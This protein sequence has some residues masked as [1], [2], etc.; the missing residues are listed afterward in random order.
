LDRRRR[1]AG[2]TPRMAGIK[3]RG[4]PSCAT[5]LRFAV[6]ATLAY[7]PEPSMARAFAGT[8]PS[9]RTPCFAWAPA[10]AFRG[11]GVRRDERPPDTRLIPA[12]PPDCC[13]CPAHPAALGRPGQ[14]LRGLPVH[15]ANPCATHSLRRLGTGPSLPWLGRSP[16]RASTGHSPYSGSPP[17]ASSV[18]ASPRLRPAHPI[19]L[20]AQ[21]VSMLRRK[22]GF[23]VALRSLTLRRPTATHQPVPERIA[24]GTRGARLGLVVGWMVPPC[25]ASRPSENRVFRRPAKLW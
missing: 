22:R 4:L 6:P 12:H 15:R 21:L 24:F 8:I 17:G 3:A 18:S 16:G 13:L 9:L 1:P 5:P 23:R 14:I 19:A 11:L 20:P 2:G 7:Q 25:T 10:Q